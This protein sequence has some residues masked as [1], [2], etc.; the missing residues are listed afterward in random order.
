MGFLLVISNSRDRIRFEVD[1]SYK[2]VRPNCWHMSCTAFG[3]ISKVASDRFA[4][5]MVIWI[6]VRSIGLS[7][8]SHWILL[9]LF[10]AGSLESVWIWVEYRATQ[11]KLLLVSLLNYCVMLLLIRCF[12][13]LYYVVYWSYCLLYTYYSLLANGEGKLGWAGSGLLRIGLELLF[14]LLGKFLWANLKWKG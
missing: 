12:V 2:L 6:A 4:S 1:K 7:R 8:R 9:L 3:S 11:L 13:Q 14:V 10:G 5:W